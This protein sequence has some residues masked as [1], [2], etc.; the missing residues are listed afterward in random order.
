MNKTSPENKQIERGV[1]F[2]VISYQRTGS[3]FFVSTLNKIDGVVCHSELFNN[4]FDSF[5]NSV[6]DDAL[7]PELNMFDKL[8][9]VSRFEKL[10]RYKKVNPVRFLDNIFRYRNGTTGFKLFPGQNEIILNKILKDRS[11]KKIILVR[12]NV[13]RSFVSREVA[14]KTGK[15]GRYKNE[16]LSLVKITM[17]TDRFMDYERNIKDRFSK[18]ESVLNDSA[19]NY[20][21]LTYEQISSSYPLNQVCAFLEIPK[22]DA[23][24]DIN[25]VKQNPFPLSEMIENYNEVRQFFNNTDYIKFL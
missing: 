24:P 18:I 14:L 20:L 16:D 8:L 11:V 21:K 13:I 3:T 10:F 2:V 17:D 1:K 4:G 6:F 9:G 19:Q 12:K 22:P 23:L 25:Q 5:V 7:L 15:W